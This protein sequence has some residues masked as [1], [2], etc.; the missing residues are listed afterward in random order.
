[1]QEMIRAYFDEYLEELAD[2]SAIKPPL[3]LSFS[4]SED[5]WRHLAL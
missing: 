1:M 2:N 4:K 3:I 5:F